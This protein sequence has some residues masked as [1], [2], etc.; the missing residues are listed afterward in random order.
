MRSEVAMAFS[1]GGKRRV[2]HVDPDTGDERP[3]LH[4]HQN[5]GAFLLAEQH[6]VGPAQIGADIRRARDRFGRGEPKRHGEHARA[7]GAKG[8]PQDEGHVQTGFGL[9]VPQ[10]AVAALPGGL[11]L[12]DDDRA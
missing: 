6:V 9:G 2:I 10:A 8:Q 5:A 4:L 11:L 12:G 1:S 7:L 3:G